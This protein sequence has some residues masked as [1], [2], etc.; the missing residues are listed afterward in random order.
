VGDIG[1]NFNVENNYHNFGPRFGLAYQL[2]ERTV[3]RMGYGRSYDIG[4]FGSIFGHAVTQNL[5]V[6]EVQNNNAADNF[7]NVFTLATGP[8][9]PVFPS[10]PSN[11]LLPLPNGVF[12]RARPTRMR[13]PR[14]DAYNLTVQH[15]L[16]NTMSMELA[17]VGNNG[18]GFYANNPDVNVNQPTI[19]GFGTVSR[20]ERRPYFNKY[21][22]TQDISFFGNDAPSY[23]DALQAKLD[24][25]FSN[26]LQF[27]AHYT[28][29]KNLTH[30]GSY[31]NIDP[32]V[33]YGPDDFNRKHVFSISSVYEL[34]F[35]KGKHFMGNAGRALNLL[36]G[37]FQLNTTT[38]YSSGLPW[39]PQY[40]DCGSDE[41]TG[42]C[43]PIVVGSLSQGA[44][45]FDPVAG[46]VPY[47]TPVAELTA[48]GQ[49][50]GPFQRPQA[51]TFGSGRNPFYGPRFFNADMSL[52]KNFAITERFA[53]Q[54]RFEAFNVFN[55]VNLGQP[56][57][58]V[59]CGGGNITGIAANSQMRQL[60]FGLKVTF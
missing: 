45:H 24:K 47:Y 40:K 1:R 46:V 25:R 57:N 38:N 29:S 20:D 35:G 44:G 11:G 50:N 14:L 9:A 21:G 16:T 36:I 19:V 28:W 26:G 10:V 53:A 17:F 5:P 7:A 31:A 54:F 58:C 60:N 12:A 18:H 39:S 15:Q 37:G 34:P 51:G 4:V 3:V 43:R 33:N 48:N 41:D 8:D 55:H 30:D 22:W 6:L 13:L 32:Q 42:P 27:V 2:T 59:D 23:Y 52:F 56:N 49:I